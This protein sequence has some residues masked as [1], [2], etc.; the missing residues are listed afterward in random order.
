MSMN[1]NFLNCLRTKYSFWVGDCHGHDHMVVGFMT[2]YAISTLWVQIL[3]RYI[4]L[5]TRLCDKVCQWLV[6]GRWFSPGT[7][8]S[9]T[10]KTD[11]LDIN[12]I[13][14]KVAL[15][16]IITHPSFW[17]PIIASCFGFLFIGY[18]YLRSYRYDSAVF[19]CLSTLQKLPL[20]WWNSLCFIQRVFLCTVLSPYSFLSSW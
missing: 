18:I 20:F 19:V 5:D 17:V 2:T 9:S 10:N 7:L 11:Y 16:S 6:A 4:I 12:E 13:L 1:L 14:L 8:V 3:F 15:N